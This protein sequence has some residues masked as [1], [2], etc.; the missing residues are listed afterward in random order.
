LTT[1]HA[2]VKVP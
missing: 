1:G 2:V